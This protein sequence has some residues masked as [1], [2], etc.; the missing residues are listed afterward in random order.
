MYISLKNTVKLCGLQ[1]RRC[2]IKVF[3]Y[4]A[5][6]M[7]GVSGPACCGLGYQPCLHGICATLQPVLY[8]LCNS[9]QLDMQTELT[10]TPCASRTH[11]EPVWP[12]GVP[13]VPTERP[14]WPG[15]VPALLA[16]RDLCDQVVC[17]PYLPRTCVTRWCASLD[18][19][20]RPVWPGGVPALLAQWDLCDQ[21]V[22]KP[23]PQRTCMTRRCAS[24][25]CPEICVTRWFASLACPK[26]PVWPGGVPT[27]LA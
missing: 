12:G 7:D 16:Q 6:M 21:V 8:S 1:V 25:V 2:S 19:L 11:R 4:R 22:C 10:L 15:G 5:M 23:Y 14:V 3:V 26:R 9:K 17:Q 20:E 13:A 24:F 27:M 18:C